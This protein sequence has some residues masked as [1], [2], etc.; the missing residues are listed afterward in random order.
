VAFNHF[1]FGKRKKMQPRAVLNPCHFMRESN[2]SFVLISLRSA[3]ETRLGLGS[4]FVETR[5]LQ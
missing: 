5:L 3:P 1:V 2:F 4:N